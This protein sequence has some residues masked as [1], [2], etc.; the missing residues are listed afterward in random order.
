VIPQFKLLE[1][2]G[3]LLA[4]V[5][6]VGIVVSAYKMVDSRGY[7]RG[8]TEERAKWQGR[9]AKE[10]AAANAMILIESDKARSAERKAAIAVNNANDV[11]RKADEA[12]KQN[13]AVVAVGVADGLGRL[14]NGGAAGSQ[15]AGSDSAGPDT[16][17][18]AG[19]DATDRAEFLAAAGGFLSSEADRADQVTRLFGQA[20]AYIVTVLETCNAP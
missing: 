11:R 8:A 3:V 13:V 16:A 6:L 10:L 4:L 19:A 1:I 9:E 20:Q 14:C 7:T 12:G 17:T 2:A 18:A 15:G 5:A